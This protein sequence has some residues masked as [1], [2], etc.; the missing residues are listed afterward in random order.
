MALVVFA[1]VLVASFA[2]GKAYRPGLYAPWPAEP[3]RRHFLCV[4]AGQGT[5]PGLRVA[6]TNG[7]LG[8]L[9]L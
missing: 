6:I 9:L 5:L 7:G 8:A 4:G 3:N 1:L 2:N